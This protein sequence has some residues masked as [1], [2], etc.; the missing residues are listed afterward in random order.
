MLMQRLQRQIRRRSGQ[1]DCSRAVAGSLALLWRK[2]MGGCRSGIPLHTEPA[3]AHETIVEGLVW[4]V[5]GRCIAPPQAMADNMD[6]AA[7]HPP[8]VHA[9]DAMRQRE[10]GVEPAHLN[11]RLHAICAGHGW[12]VVLLLTKGQATDHRGAALMLP[13]ISGRAAVA[14]SASRRMPAA[15]SP[16]PTSSAQPGPA[17]QRRRAGQPHH[18]YAPAPDPPTDDT[19]APAL[20]GSQSGTAPPIRRGAVS[21]C[22]LF[23]DPAGCP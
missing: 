19:P 17:R 4:A 20:P 6:D 11:S 9:Q 2:W 23:L 5:A 13:I 12:P 21:D 7:D 22:L 1:R 18:T 8:V 10:E 16:V 3:P 14:G 15:A